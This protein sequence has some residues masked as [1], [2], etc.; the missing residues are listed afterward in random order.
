[1][2]AFTL[3]RVPLVRLDMIIAKKIMEKIKD[4]RRGRKRARG[5]SGRMEGYSH[6]Q[7]RA[8]DRAYNRKIP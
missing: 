2:T 8:S 6:R 4:Y 5:D 7:F 3:L 1:M